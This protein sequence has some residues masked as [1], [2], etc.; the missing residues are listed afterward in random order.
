[1]PECRGEN[2]AARQAA[3][4]PGVLENCGSVEPCSSTA[5]AD[6]E[7]WPRRSRGLLDSNADMESL[8]IQPAGGNPIAKCWR[9]RG[10]A[11]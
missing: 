10:I 2:G 3:L 11:R 7:V 5:V 9:S 6:A 1:V 8:I 4:D